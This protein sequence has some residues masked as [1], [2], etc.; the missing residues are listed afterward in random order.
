MKKSFKCTVL[1]LGII[2]SIIVSL[3]GSHFYRQ[4]SNNVMDNVKKWQMHGL[5]IPREGQWECAELNLI[6]DYDKRY[7]IFR[8]PSIK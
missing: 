7:C 4:W 3:I 1:I 6:I 8:K 5:E 2:A